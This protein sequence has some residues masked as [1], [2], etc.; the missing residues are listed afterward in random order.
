MW[1]VIMKVF[2][3]LVRIGYEKCDSSLGWIGQSLK[4]IL[5]EIVQKYTYV[6]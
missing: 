3:G 5:K 6:D 4:L 1:A 2:L